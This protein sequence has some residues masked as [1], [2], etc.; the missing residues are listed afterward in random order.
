MIKNNIDKKLNLKIHTKKRTNFEVYLNLNSYNEK[1][2]LK[3]FSLHTS[4]YRR[5]KFNCR[6]DWNEGAMY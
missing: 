5:G 4:S 1:N 2:N 3:I 6:G